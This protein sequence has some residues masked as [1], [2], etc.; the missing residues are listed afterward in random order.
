[1][2][3]K[4]IEYLLLNSFNIDFDVFKKIVN[5]FKNINED[6]KEEMINTFNKLIKEP[7]DKGFLY[8]AT[9]YKV[10]NNE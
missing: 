3:K 10:K 1:M 8:K 2:K 6:N 9:V 4:K 7:M 5:I